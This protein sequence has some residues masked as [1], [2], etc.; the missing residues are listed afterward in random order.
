V[1]DYRRHFVLGGCYFFSVN[2]LERRRTL[3]TDHIDLLRDSVRRVKRLYPFHIDAW[4]VLPDHMHLVLTLPSDTDDFSVRLRLI[5][6]LFAKGLPR[7]ERLSASRRKR[8]ERCVWQRRFW[9]HAIRDERD[10]AHHVDYVHL[11]P[12]KH[13]YV[14]RVRDW[15]FST[16]HRYVQNKLLPSDWAGALA[17]NAGRDFGERL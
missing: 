13:G 7:T 8:H 11:N 4:V 15:P 12:L 6:L 9:E 10:Y 5:K 17:N 2:L 1:P 14:S 3:L 16:F